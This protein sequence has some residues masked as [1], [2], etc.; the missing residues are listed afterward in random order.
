MKGPSPA[1]LKAAAMPSLLVLADVMWRDREGKAGVRFEFADEEE[2]DQ[3][4]GGLIDALLARH[5]LS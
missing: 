1:R 3:W 5:A 4:S 2:R